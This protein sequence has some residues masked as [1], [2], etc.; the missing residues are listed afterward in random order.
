LKEARKA[1]KG[2]GINMP[3]KPDDAFEDLKINVKIK[4]SALWA[5]V[6][7]CYVYGDYFGLYTPGTVQQMIAGKM[8][9]LGAATQ[10]VL[11]GT[12]A[13]MAIPSLMVFLSLVLPPRVNRVLNVALGII[14]TLIIL[15][16]MPGTWAYYIFF[17]VIEVVLTLSVAWYAWKWPR[18][19]V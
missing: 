15:A 16:S 9:P 11:V 6:M 18:H 10:G 8:G 12:S 17:G 4:L 5:A 19:R 3:K 13:M 7:F 1:S 2:T 14:Y